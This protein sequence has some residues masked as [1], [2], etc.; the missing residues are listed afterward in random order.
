MRVRLWGVR[1]SM[2]ASGTPFVRH[3]G[4]T[5]CVEV[6]GEGGERVVLDAGSGVVP[7]G[8]ALMQE[9]F[10]KGQG[11]LTLA[12]SHCVSVRQTPWLT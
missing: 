11:R 9:G 10:G 5:P 4:N 6:R 1:G 7:L 3:G 2:P 12:L 8:R